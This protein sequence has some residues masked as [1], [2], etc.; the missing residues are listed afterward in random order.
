MHRKETRVLYPSKSAFVLPPPLWGLPG[1][2]PSWGWG[3]HFD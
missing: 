1:R 3:R 2:V